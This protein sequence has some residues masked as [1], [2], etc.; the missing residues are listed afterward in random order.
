[1]G[2]RG[3][4][5][6][7][8]HPAQGGS[9]SRREQQ[10]QQQAEERSERA[11]CW[12]WQQVQPEP[13]RDLCRRPGGEGRLYRRRRQPPCLPGTV[14]QVDCRWTCHLGSWIASDVPGVYARMSHFTQWINE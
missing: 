6:I 3:G 5:F 11:A 8:V 7:P 13:E 12:K 14:W 4:R 9:P 2:E 10:L 1:M